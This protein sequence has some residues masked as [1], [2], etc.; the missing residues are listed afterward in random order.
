MTFNQVSEESIKSVAD[1]RNYI[2]RK[3]LGY[4]TPVEAFF[5]EMAKRKKPNNGFILPQ[6]KC[7]FY[8]DSRLYNLTE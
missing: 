1:K 7:Q 6:E 5:K 2:P 4:Q 8:S 3:S